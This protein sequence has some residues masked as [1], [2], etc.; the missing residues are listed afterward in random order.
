MCTV[1][2]GGSHPRA[3]FSSPQNKPSL[4][5]YK[6][7]AM[8]RHAPHIAVTNCVFLTPRLLPPSPAPTRVC[9]SPQ[10]SLPETLNKPFLLPCVLFGL[11]SLILWLMSIS[12]ELQLQCGAPSAEHN[13]CKTEAPKCWVNKRKNV[14]RE[15]KS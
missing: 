5:A 12:S 14:G 9:D 10:W 8:D 7:P 3:Q 13:A 11:V 6:G 2:S 4:R 1:T 15:Y